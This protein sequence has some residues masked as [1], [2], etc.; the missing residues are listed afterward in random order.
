MH[1]KI[2][3]L[4]ELDFLGINILTNQHVIV[5]SEWKY[6]HSTAPF[7]RLYYV[8]S[9][10]AKMFFNGETIEMLP[11]NVYL[12]PSDVDFSYRCEEG[13]TLEKIYFH[14]F[15]TTPEKYD[16]LSTLPPGV[17]GLSF[18]EAEAEDLFPLYSQNNYHSLL[19][20]KSIVYRTA[21]AFY[22]K[23]GQTDTAIKHY[24]ETVR[25]AINYIQIHFSA[26]FNVQNMA[27]EL[28]VSK[29]KISKQ[30]K[31][32]IGMTISQYNEDLVFS[33]A[34]ML[35]LQ[36]KVPIQRISATLGF[37]DQFYFSRRFKKKFGI[38]PAQYRK[39]AFSPP[40]ID[41]KQ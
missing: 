20:I 3:Q 30:F 6:D 5:G 12:I 16:L 18:A 39:G 8:K 26:K 36:N 40:I 4:R 7:S 28:F 10:Y 25:E 22:D 17:Y 24:S 31:Q 38:S 33:R 41:K 29:S 32:E 9:G 15:I 34:K 1:N 14:I 27:D 21:I 37:C 11:G 13:D 35:L 19:K 2:A 23:F